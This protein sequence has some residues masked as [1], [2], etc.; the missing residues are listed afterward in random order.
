MICNLNNIAYILSAMVDSIVAALILVAI[1]EI[2]KEAIYLIAGKL[3][4]VFSTAIAYWL[5][6]SRGSASKDVRIA[7]LV[8]KSAS[9]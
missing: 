9:K 8:S 5:I 7:E 6:S 1:P 4:V 2:N 3:F